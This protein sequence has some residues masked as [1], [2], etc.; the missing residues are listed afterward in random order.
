MSTIE[1]ELYTQLLTDA[2]LSALIGNRILPDVAP[3][4]ITLPSVVYARQA[5]AESYLLEGPPYFAQVRIGYSCLAVNYLSAMRVLQALRAKALTVKGTFNGITIDSV[6]VADER[7]QGF[8]PI[9]N[10]YQ[11]DLD[12]EIYQ[13]L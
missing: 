12:L 4:Q 13:Q 8:N 5:A 10:S 9:T 7:D 3:G 2:T 11:I 6:F 1:E